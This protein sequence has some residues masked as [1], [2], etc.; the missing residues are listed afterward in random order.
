MKT[1]GKLMAAGI[2]VVAAL[3]LIRPA[4]PAKPETAKVALPSDV[5]KILE[6]NCYSC[7]S[8]QRRLS[9][10]DEI[11]PGYWLVRHDILTAREHLNFSTFGSKP[12]AAQKATLFEAVNFMRL[13]AMPLGDFVALHPEA[14]VSPEELATFEVYLAPSATAS[15]LVPPEK[16]FAPDAFAK[17][18]PEHNGLPFDP[19][20]VNWKVLSTT[21]RS[22][23][24]TVRFILG[25]DIAVQAARTGN[26][27]PWPDGTRFAK[28]AW[29][30]SAA[31]DGLMYP[32]GFVQ[33]EL[34]VKD[35]DKFKKTEGWGWGRWRGVDLK[36]Y[37]K[38]AD[39][40]KECTSCHQPVKGND[41]VYTLPITEAKVPGKEVVNNLAA[42]MPAGM[43]NN[44]LSWNAI[45]M[46]VDPKMHTTATLFGNDAAVHSAKSSAYPPGATLALV[47]W[48]Q[49]EDPHWFG[50]RIPAAV[51]YVEFVMVS[52]AEPKLGNRRF[53]A[54]GEDS[55]APGDT[56]YRVG[57][58]TG[59][60][61]AQ[62]P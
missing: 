58:I 23:N 24:F 43:P 25:N 47:T 49:R 41:F 44:P 34:M 2:F 57:F 55:P 7:H 45:T 1:L 27:S 5:Q 42:A 32:F 12:A 26:I 48:N 31:D 21:D 35:A 9:W 20:F 10:F 56:R 13:G 60:A 38:D 33:V 11:V 50:A 18:L 8:N 4:I 30:R 40:A 17:V 15:E 59:L 37:G 22:D 53:T 29:H 61:P 16:A 36:P 19:T 51:E 6:K 14:K 28:I 52:D 62:L 46:Y 3:Q 54:S 39:F